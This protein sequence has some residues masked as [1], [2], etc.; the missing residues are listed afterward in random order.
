MIFDLGN[1]L[2]DRELHVGLHAHLNW[3]FTAPGLYELTFEARAT[4]VDGAELTSPARTYR[5]W[6]GALADLPAT[7]P[8]LVAVSGLAAGYAQGDEMVL[9]PAQFGAPSALEAH[10]FRQCYLDP[11]M[12]LAV[13]P[14]EEL[15][16]VAGVLTTTVVG[17]CQYRVSLMDGMTPVATSQAVTPS[18]L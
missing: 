9:S 8:T 6:L 16:S 18:L 2:R 17:G 7:A 14:W 4:A 10:W 3:A 15:P 13:G 5:F 11:T 1:D 12:S